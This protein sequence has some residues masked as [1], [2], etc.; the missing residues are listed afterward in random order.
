MI[1]WVSSYPKS[2]NTWVRS[3]LGTYLYSDNGIFNFNLLNKIN[4]FPGRQHFEFFLKDFKDL[5]K[6]SSHW[7]AAQDRLNLSNDGIVFLKTHNALCTIENNSFTNKNN[8]KAVIYVVRDPRNVITSLSH[9]YRMNTEE[10]FNFMTDSTITLVDKKEYDSVIQVLGDWSNNFQSWKNIKFAPI[11][12]VK[13]E[14]LIIDTKKT[15]LSILNFLKNFMNIKI[16]ENKILKTV[17]SCSFE[18]VR[19]KEEIEGFKEAVYSKKKDKK[20]KFFYLGK[21][22]NW[23]NLLDPKIEEQ[24]RLKFNKEMKELEYN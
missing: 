6:I 10:A 5:K 8:T 7:I 1:I 23:K 13:Y 16:D 14:D 18:S 11:L 20:L 12:I 19:K 3:L 2:G 24:I 9:H 15:F 17:E 22:N 4:L 21:Q